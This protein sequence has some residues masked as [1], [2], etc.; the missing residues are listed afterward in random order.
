MLRHSLVPA[1]AVAGLLG[2]ALPTS[3]VLADAESTPSTFNM[4]APGYMRTA[5]FRTPTERCK[6]YQHRFDAALASHQQAAMLDEAKVLRIEGAQLCTAGSHGPG[7]RK[8]REA[9]GYLGVDS[10]L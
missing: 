3:P 2:L 6:I 10:K 4:P 7:A 8:L 9:L 1:A 5:T